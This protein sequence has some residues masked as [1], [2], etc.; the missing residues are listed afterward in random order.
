MG[1]LTRVWMM[2]GV[3][4]MYDWEGALNRLGIDWEGISTARFS[5]FFLN[6][7][8]VTMAYTIPLIHAAE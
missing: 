8:L 2:R 5:W 3:W 4:V 1:L 6:M 7:V